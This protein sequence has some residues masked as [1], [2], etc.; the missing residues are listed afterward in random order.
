MNYAQFHVDEV[1][2]PCKKGRCDNV[3]RAIAGEACDVLESIYCWD[4]EDIYH[5]WSMINDYY[6]LKMYHSGG[7]FPSI[8]YPRIPSVIRKRLV[9]PGAVIA[10]D[11][12]GQFL[13]ASPRL[14]SYMAIK[15]VDDICVVGKNKEVSECQFARVA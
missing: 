13:H 5:L 6:G 8:D 15:R 7:G 11:K 3:N 12:K 1:L 10:M 2:V 9:S 4:T 14:F